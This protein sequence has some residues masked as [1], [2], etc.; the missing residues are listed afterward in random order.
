MCE[1]MCVH[2]RARM[3]MFVRG[4]NASREDHDLPVRKGSRYIS[5]RK[6]WTTRL[7]YVS[8]RPLVASRTSKFWDVELRE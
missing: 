2:A 1:Y 8:Y 5:M 3:R 7:T 6:R 4:G